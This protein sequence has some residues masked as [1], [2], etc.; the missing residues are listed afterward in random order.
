MKGSADVVGLRLAL[1]GG[2]DDIRNGERMNVR[3]KA[4]LARNDV[5]CRALVAAKMTNL[6]VLKNHAMQGLHCAGRTLGGHGGAVVLAHF[7][8]QAA[9]RN[10]LAQ[11]RSNDRLLPC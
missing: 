4:S 6:G 10:L 1:L 3:V 11:A 2:I 8:N 7:E 5:S 9:L